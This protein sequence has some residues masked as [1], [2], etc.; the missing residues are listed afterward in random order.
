MEFRKMREDELQNWY[1][2]ELCEAFPPHERK[3]LPVIRELMASGCYT[4]WGLYD[5]GTLLGYSALWAPGE[6]AQQGTAYVVLDYLG[7]TAA[8]RNAGI[9]AQILARLGERGI[10]VIIESE[11]PSPGVDEVENKIRARRIGFYERAGYQGRY[12]MAACGSRFVAMTAGGPEDVPAMLAAHR[13]VYGA[14]RP[15]VK[16]PLEPGEAPPPAFWGAT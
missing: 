12:E 5:G 4:L 1:D 8:R 9:G 14:R 2:R 16:I 13:A 15:D 6:G 7:V 10:R 11:C 3:P